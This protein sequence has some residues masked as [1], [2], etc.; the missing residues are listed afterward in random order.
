MK[1][2]I[3]YLF[4]MVAIAVSSC[5][6]GENTPFGEPSFEVS[7]SQLFLGQEV[8]FTNE[9]QFANF[10]SWDF[11]DGSTSDQK[12][13]VHMYSTPG[14]YKVI[15]T[16]DDGSWFSRIVT[17]HEGDRAVYVVNDTPNDLDITFFDPVSD[18]EIGDKRYPLGIVKSNT[19]SDTIYIKDEALGIAG[20]RAGK[21]FLILDPFAFHLEKGKVNKVEINSTTKILSGVGLPE[22]K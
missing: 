17:V 14:E 7:S 9:S 2:S 16:I 5:S 3:L 21:P 12:D 13:P 22:G 18:D 10:Y 15:L 11:G 20:M 8:S 4:V 19:V 1:K 6:K